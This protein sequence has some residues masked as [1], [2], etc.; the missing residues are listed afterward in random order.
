[1]GSFDVLDLGLSGGGIDKCWDF[2][3]CGDFCGGDFGAWWGSV[4]GVRSGLK[5][6]QGVD[7]M[8]LVVVGRG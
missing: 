3:D 2:N 8:G 1:M 4:R 7:F 5:V 6:A